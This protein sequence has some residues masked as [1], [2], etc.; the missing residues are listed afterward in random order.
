LARGDVEATVTDRIKPSL[1]LLSLF[2]LKTTTLSLSGSKRVSIIARTHLSPH[3]V[4]SAA[5]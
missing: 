5:E 1:T 4:S 3:Q 2:L